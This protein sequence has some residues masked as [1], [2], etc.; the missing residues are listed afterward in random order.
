VVNAQQY[1]WFKEGAGCGG[2][3]CFQTA[4]AMLLAVQSI[5]VAAILTYVAWLCVTA[6][7]NFGQEQLSARDML[8]VWGRCVLVLMIILYLI[9]N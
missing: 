9:I 2:G 5:G 6:Y 7:N 8:I 3:P 4:D 1:Q